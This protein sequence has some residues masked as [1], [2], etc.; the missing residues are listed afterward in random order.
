MQC[1]CAILSPVAWPA[2]QHFFHITYLLTPWSRVLLEKLTDS[3]ASQ[4]IPPNFWNPKVHHRTHKCPP[5]IPILSQLHP[6]PTTPSHFLKIHL[7]IILPSESGSPQWSLSLRF[8][9]QYPDFYRNKSYW[10]KNVSLLSLRCLSGTFIMLRR[11]MRYDHKKCIGLHV[12]YPLF[13]S[14]F[15]EAWIFLDRFSKNTQISNNMKILPV[16]AELF[17]AEWRTDTIKLIVALRNFAK[18][19]KK[20]IDDTRNGWVGGITIVSLL[21][22]DRHP[23]SRY[24]V[25]FILITSSSICDYTAN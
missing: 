4:E 22:D 9:H 23:Q 17:H 7:N 14:D 15:N 16:W 13:L 18:G 8:P 11:I 12:K 1:A 19:P 25:R 21:Q 3:A 6:V 5:H 24:A 10:T 20:R 2:V